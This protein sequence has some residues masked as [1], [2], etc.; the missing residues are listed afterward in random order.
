MSSAS[1]RLRAAGRRNR[2]RRT[3]A[4]SRACCSPAGTRTDVSS[5]P[6]FPPLLLR[7]LSDRL[8]LSGQ[9]L[10]SLLDGSGNTLLRF[11]FRRGGSNA[12]LRGNVMLGYADDNVGRA[13]LV[14]ERSAH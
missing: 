12:L 14:T 4:I 2:G 3:T 11:G 9:R 1:S 7:R 8:F 13:A 5:V 6:R 10:A